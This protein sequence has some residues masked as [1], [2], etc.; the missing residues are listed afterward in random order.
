MFWPVRAIVAQ[1]RDVD[2]EP[3]ILARVI[4]CVCYQNF[5]HQNPILLSSQDKAIRQM[6]LNDE[7]ISKIWLPSWR[8][9][10]VWARVRK[11]DRGWD[12][13]SQD[14]CHVFCLFCNISQFTP[15]TSN[16]RQ[17]SLRFLNLNHDKWRKWSK[18]DD[19]TMNFNV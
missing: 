4:E 8:V 3:S 9:S 11:L 19:V 18:K 5:W 17:I 1:V 6:T 14:I 10:F 13:S 12:L 7:Y 2:S 16:F 15:Q